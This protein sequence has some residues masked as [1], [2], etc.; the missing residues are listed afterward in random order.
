MSTYTYKQVAKNPGI[1]TNLPTDSVFFS[2]GRN[3]RIR[4]GAIYK[5]PGQ[6]EFVGASQ[7]FPVR[8]L[9]NFKGYDNV[10]RTIACCD[11]KIYSYT[12]DFATVFNATPS[13]PP[14]S[15]LTDV[16]QFALVG[17]MPVLSNGVNPPWKWSNFAAVMTPLANAPTICKA[18]HTHMN[19]VVAGNIQE[20]A[21][22]FPSRVRWS[23]IAQAEDWA[24]D[25]KG[26]SG[27]KDLINPSSSLN[28]VDAIKAI[29]H[30]GNKL[31]VFTD[32]N[33]WFGDAT[34]ESID[35]IW[36][37]LDRGVG[38]VAPRAFVRSI[39]G[40]LYFMGE[41]DF[42]S[43]TEDKGLRPIGFDIQNS[44]FPN[45]NKNAISTAFCYDRPATKEIVF[46]VATGTNTTPDTA[47][48]YQEE[49]KAWTIEDCAYNAR[50]VALTDANFT[51]DTLP[52][53]SW[54]TITDGR[55]DL[56]S[57]TGILPYEVGAN[58]DGKIFKLEYGSNKIDGTGIDGYLET[59]DMVFGNAMMNKITDEIIPYLKM[60]A[61]VSALMVQV[62][63]RDSLHKD[64][65]W[66][67][68]F[69]YTVGVSRHVNARKQGK[70][71]RLRFYSNVANSPWVLEGYQIKFQGGGS[72]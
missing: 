24:K 9:F 71:I 41:T 60:Q 31:I 52:F 59:G 18:L 5:S 63:T 29:T 28:G 19:R 58:S 57:N 39:S 50:V 26:S 36:A 68:P 20:G 16:W 25:L 34:P 64:I 45:L 40:I 27:A 2:T 8:A 44:C 14:S 47:F 70:Y 3:V 30:I 4:P 23:N 46:C 12:T 37:S 55:W 56:M 49:V 11:T 1:V 7:G 67:L 13:T 32:R 6:S 66:S 42:Y 65:D 17:G 10:W 72:R 48:V 21:Y 62:G 15:T 35:Y 22:D 61:D 51:W 33:I 53:G 69:P 43:Y 54:D 38:L